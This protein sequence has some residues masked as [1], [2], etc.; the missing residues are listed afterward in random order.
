MRTLIIPAAGSSSRFPGVRPKWLLSHPDGRLMLEHSIAGVLDKFD[1][2]IIAVTRPVYETYSI[3]RMLLSM[4]STKVTPFVVDG[5]TNGPAD[6]V[7]QTLVGNK[8]SGSFAVRDTDSAIAIEVDDE[9]GNAVAYVS[10]N[11]FDVSR[12]A[13]KSYIV[14][15]SEG[16]ILDI[17][18]KKVVSDKVSTGFYSFESAEK[19]NEWYQGVSRALAHNPKEDNVEI[20][21]SNVIQH[22]IFSSPDIFFKAIECRKFRDYGT[23]QEW[24]TEQANYSTYVCDFDGVLVKNSGK[25]G[26]PNWDSE[27]IP[28]ERNLKII[29]KKQAMGAQVIIMSSR[30][31][32]FRSRITDFL[33]REEIKCHAI[34]LDCNHA[35]R[36]L[37]NDFAPSNPWPSAT[38]V[39]VPRDG[40]LSLYLR[41]SM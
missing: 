23:I 17:V 7:Y 27:F 20:Y 8:V 9:L 6:T 11:K 18:E 33:E 12:I 34:V 4:F 36:V 31:E 41:T 29:R 19:Y 1:R 13:A 30:P 21:V 39:S 35:P 26:E 3:N 16:A 32:K 40:D 5:P 37:I 10:L 15:N 24:H 28:L 25:F 22:A 14:C 2:A 38:A